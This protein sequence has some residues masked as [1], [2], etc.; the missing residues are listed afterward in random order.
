MSEWC[1]AGIKMSKFQPPCT[2]TPSIEDVANLRSL[3]GM[4]NNL[5][6]LVHEAHVHH[7]SFVEKRVLELAGRI[8]E[9]IVHLG[10]SPH[11]M[12][13]LCQVSAHT[14]AFICTF[15][16]ISIERW[17]WHVFWRHTGWTVQLYSGNQQPFGQDWH[18]C[19]AYS[20]SVISPDW[21]TEPRS[22]PTTSNGSTRTK[23]STVRR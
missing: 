9:V 3:S 7:F 8:D 23:T 18:P 5:N 16:F 13:L 21:M 19:Q 11:Y 4:A 14:W 12:H 15:F 20:F 10:N 22:E 17:T 6:Q 1:L 2:S